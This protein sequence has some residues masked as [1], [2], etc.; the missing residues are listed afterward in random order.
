MFEDMLTLGDS[1]CF[2]ALSS[3]MYERGRIAKH[4]TA[5]HSAAQH[6]IA[7]HSTAGHEAARHRTALR[8]VVELA[9]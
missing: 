5:R 7:R 6:G 1:V 8:R 3:G 9:S 4:G 2:L